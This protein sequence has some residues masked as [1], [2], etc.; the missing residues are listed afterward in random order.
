MIG[1]T[2]Y[3]IEMGRAAGVK[4]VGVDWGYHPAY[5]LGADHLVTDFN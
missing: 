5:K 3:D 2:T 4:T 1:D